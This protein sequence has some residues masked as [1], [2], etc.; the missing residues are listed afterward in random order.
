M[1]GGSGKFAEEH[2]AEDVALYKKQYKDL[3]ARMPIVSV[4]HVDLQI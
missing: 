1:H 4:T 2:L 3:P